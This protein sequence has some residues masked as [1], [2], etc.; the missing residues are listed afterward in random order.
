METEQA[1]TAL[2]LPKPSSLEAAAIR[3]A[4]LPAPERKRKATRLAAA[5]DCSGLSAL[6]EA[7]GALYGSRGVLMSSNTLDAYRLSVRSL[8]AFC[9]AQGWNLVR[10]A[11]DMA[12]AWKLSLEA[13]GRSAATIRQRLAAARALGAALR[14]AGV[15]KSDFFPSRIKPAKDLTSRS[16]KAKSYNA[17]DIQALIS[18]ADTTKDCVSIALL[19]HG[20]R[21]AELLALR[22]N[23]LDEKRRLLTVFGKGGK[24]RT[25]FL[26]GS[27]YAF[28]LALRREGEQ[29]IFPAI[30]PQ[31][32]R[33]RLKRLCQAAGVTYLGAHGLRHYCGE[34]LYRLSG[35]LGLVADHLGHAS[36]DTARIYA[37]KSLELENTIR[38][39]ILP[40]LCD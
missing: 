32:F 10:P 12:A 9:R 1:K 27:A 14:W 34:R 13:A 36:I 37:K 8:C 4:Q 30:T 33:K 11:Q 38:G 5:L 2:T 23:D 18:A 29:V 21:L 22:W 40:S 39:G 3:W 28:L 26:D 17:G 25:V 6:S 16:E 7:Y 24:R 19:A 35:D 20:L 15:T 31:G